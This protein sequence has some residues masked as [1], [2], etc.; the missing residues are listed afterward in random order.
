MNYNIEDVKKCFIAN[1]IDFMDY[2]EDCKTKTRGRPRKETSV[3]VRKNTDEDTLEV[4][5]VTVSGKDY[6]KSKEGVL[7]DIESYD[8]CGILKDNNIE[9]II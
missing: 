7:L 6:Y 4:V 1:N 5:R 3:E 2:F 8:I 9:D